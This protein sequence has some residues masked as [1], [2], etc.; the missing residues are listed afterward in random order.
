MTVMHT[1]LYISQSS[2]SFSQTASWANL[3]CLQ[4]SDLSVMEMGRNN[5]EKVTLSE[6]ALK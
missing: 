4:S 1:H 3:V 6:D 5:W 2:L